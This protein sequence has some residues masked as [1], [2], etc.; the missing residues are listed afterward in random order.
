MSIPLGFPDALSLDES[1][2]RCVVVFCVVATMFAGRIA[3]ACRAG[4]QAARVSV[5][6]AWIESLST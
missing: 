5:P 1:D 2:N 3:F 4:K 6:N